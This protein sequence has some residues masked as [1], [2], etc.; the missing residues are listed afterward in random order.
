MVTFKPGL[1]SAKSSSSL[2]LGLITP[3]KTRSSSK[4]AAALTDHS[5][6]VGPPIGI[7][8]D[9]SADDIPDYYKSDFAPSPPLDSVDRFGSS[10][11][12]ANGTFGK[13]EL[14]KMEKDKKKK[15]AKDK[16]KLKAGAPLDFIDT[17]DTIGGC[18]SLFPCFSD[19]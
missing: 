2:G 12:S 11:A 9:V 18:A 14:A 19:A 8:R 5:P 4:K 10:P 15:Q 1:P 13:K 7:G 3:S 6:N 16:K 17:L